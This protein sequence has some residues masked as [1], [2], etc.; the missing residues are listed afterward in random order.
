MR[1]NKAVLQADQ[2]KGI[3]CKCLLRLRCSTV[4]KNCTL[5]GLYCRAC[6]GRYESQE[7][8]SNESAP[9]SI[10]KLRQEGGAAPRESA[11]R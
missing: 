4:E 2:C 11:V 5:T 3:A 9:P 7:N 10:E 8:L 6:G 1:E